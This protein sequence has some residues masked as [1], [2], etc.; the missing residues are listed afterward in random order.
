MAVT[1]DEALVATAE[2]DAIDFK[3]EFN[4]AVDGEWCE[5]L[6]DVL[7]MGN[8]GGGVI[9]IG[10]D[11]AGNTVGID[12]AISKKMDPAVIGDK[13]RKYT[14]GND[15][16]CS[17]RIETR[18]SGTVLVLAIDASITPVAFEKAGTY[19]VG[20]KPKCA[21]NAGSFY[22]R[23]N[24]R[25]EPGTTEDVAAAIE[26]EVN[27]RR[28]EWLGNIRQ[29]MEA[30]PGS[31]VTFGE[32]SQASF[33]GSATTSVRLTNDATAASIAYRSRDATHPFRF[34]ALRA[35]VT[36]RLPSGTTMSAG[37]LLAIRRAFQVDRNPNWADV[38]KY[39]P[40]QYS[41]AFADWLVDQ[42][43]RD[44]RFGAKAKMKA[45]REGR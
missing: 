35:E 19:E 12:S 10:V 34:N 28:E 42:C 43:S 2:T 4:P 7:A 17:V 9:I 5:L 33:G 16:R 32:H 18:G 22:F 31:K 44:P 26:R 11:S 27:R 45:R 24:T 38:G 15:P 1:I 25:S 8:S 30:P 3:K 37:D 21:F 13:I 6:K 29:V 39:G 23:H 40:T 41:N 20:A 36:K 14:A